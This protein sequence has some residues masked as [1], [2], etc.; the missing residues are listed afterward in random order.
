MA[1]FDNYR[2]RHTTAYVY[3]LSL[4]GGNKYIGYTKNPTKRFAD[5]FSGNGA[6]WTQK[7]KPVSIDSLQRVNNVYEAKKV[8]RDVYYHIK[9]LYGK[10][11]VR[12]AGNTSSK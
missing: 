4:E 7:H 12:G 1:Y 9:Y 2:N 11:K 5:H 3:I 8:E 10:S 6:K